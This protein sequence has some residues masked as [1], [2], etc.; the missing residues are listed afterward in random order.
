MPDPAIPFGI[1]PAQFNEL[2]AK[3]KANL[4]KKDFAV[5]QADDPSKYPP[6]PRWDQVIKIDPR[7]PSPRE[8]LAFVAADLGLVDIDSLSPQTQKAVLARLAVA[9]KVRTE[10]MPEWR[11]KMVTLMTALDNAEDIISTMAWLFG[12]YIEKTG[13]VGRGIVK[14]SKLSADGINFINK[15]LRGPELTRKAKHKYMDERKMN[16]RTRTMRNVPRSK[17][18]KWLRDNLGNL[19]QAAQASESITGVGLQIGVIYGTL[20]NAFWDDSTT[21]LTVGELFADRELSR[22]GFFRPGAEAII[23]KRIAENE[24]KLAKQPVPWIKQMADWINA[25]STNNQYSRGLNKKIQDLAKIIGDNPFFDIETHALALSAF[26]MFADMASVSLR[27][28]LDTMDHERF[29]KVGEEPPVAWNHISRCIMR[30][31]GIEFNKDYV[32]IGAARYRQRLIL[33][34]ASEVGQDFLRN[35]GAWLPNDTATD[36]NAFLHSQVLTAASLT[37]GILSTTGD[38]VGIESTLDEQMVIFALDQAACPPQN[39]SLDEIAAWARHMKA[40]AG[41]DLEGWRRGG[42]YD[43]NMAYW[44]AMGR[45]PAFFNN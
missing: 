40:R 45:Q 20:E 2:L 41:S 8:Y 1:S 19:I 33:S 35:N 18:G 4:A 25:N 15:F 6:I 23:A 29:A 32:A 26:N 9:N 37:G 3:H 42:F 11:Q 14:G 17:G 44:R 28:H 38:P 7:L 30:A 24:A 12:P 21:L 39:A 22:I 16:A 13:R 10:N 31:Y 43:K 36:T 34:V 5:N 27:P